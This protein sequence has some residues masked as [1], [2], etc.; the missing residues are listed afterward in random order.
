[1]GAIGAEINTARVDDV[2][3]VIVILMHDRLKESYF[4][5]V[6]FVNTNLMIFRCYI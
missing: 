1:M 3:G 6:D 4:F 2:G 5:L